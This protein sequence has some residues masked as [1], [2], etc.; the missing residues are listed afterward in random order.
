MAR[1]KNVLAVVGML[2]ANTRFRQQFF[3]R[4]IA[5]AEGLV[6][7]LNADER[8]QILRLAGNLI[9]PAQRSLY[10][11]SV[12]TACESMHAAMGCDDTCPTP[13]CPCPDNDDVT[14]SVALQ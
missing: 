13:P 6:G 1:S 12:A 5:Y 4:P 9:E 14:P 7:D 2:C 11:S 8:E 10:Q 3:S